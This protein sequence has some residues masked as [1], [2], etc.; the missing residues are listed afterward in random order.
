MFFLNVFQMHVYK[1]FCALLAICVHVFACK[2]GDGDVCVSRFQARPA[3]SRLCAATFRSLPPA[4]VMSVPLL[5]A[6]EPGSPAVTVMYHCSNLICLI[7]NSLRSLCKINNKNRM[8]SAAIQQAA[9]F[10]TYCDVHL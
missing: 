2:L 4:T 1:R 3:A 5:D 7:C 6:V 10:P 8:E 9:Y